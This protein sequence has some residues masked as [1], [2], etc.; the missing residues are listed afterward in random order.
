MTKKLLSLIWILIPFYFLCSCENDSTGESGNINTPHIIMTLPDNNSTNINCARKIEIYFQDLMLDKSVND[1]NISISGPAGKV[2]A[3]ITYD[4]HENKA[5]LAPTSR[6]N[7]STCYTV[8]IK[9]TILNKEQTSYT[10]DYTFSFTTENLI[11]EITPSNNSTGV[12]LKSDIM[13]KFK[14]DI[15]QSTLDSGIL[16]SDNLTGNLINRHI[17][18]DTGSKTATIYSDEMNKYNNSYSIIIKP[19]LKDLHNN[20]LTND[21]YN[22]FRT[23]KLIISTDPPDNADDFSKDQSIKIVF[24]NP[25]DQTS[26]S[27]SNIVLKDSNYDQT[28]NGSLNYDDTHK[29]LTFSPTSSLQSRKRYQL[30]IK[31]G[32]KDSDGNHP[33]ADTKITFSTTSFIKKITP[34]NNSGSIPVDSKIKVKFN[35][36]VD[37]TTLTSEN[38]IIKISENNSIINGDISYTPG[39]KTMTFTPD[40]KFEYYTKFIIEL[41]ETIKD[42]S[43]NNSGE[44]ILS[45][46]TTKK[47][48]YQAVKAHIF[49]NYEMKYVHESAEITYETDIQGD[50]YIG[51]SDD[52]D[53]ES[54]TEWVKAN[55][56]TFNNAGTVNTPVITKMFAKVV[57]NG[58]LAAPEYS[59]VYRVVSGQ[60][61]EDGKFD[62]V[63]KAPYPPVGNDPFSEG[64]QK[65]NELI[66]SWADGYAEFIKGYDR[67]TCSPDNGWDDPS[68]AYGPAT[69][70]NFDIICLGN[71]GEI[72]LTFS[73]GITDGP[74]FDFAVYENAF[75]SQ[76][77]AGVAGQM[78][79][80]LA[81][82]EVSSDGVNFLRFDSASLTPG[83]VGGYGSV[84]VQHIYGLAGTQPN[85]YGNDNAF[86]TPFD[87]S[88]LR[89]KKKVTEG[90]VDL[91]NITHVRVID[92]SG[93]AHIDGNYHPCYDSFGNI[94]HDAFKTWGSG[95][96]DLEAIAVMNSGFKQPTD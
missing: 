14:K 30:I 53:A 86:G 84:N 56:Y 58:S 12:E 62:K 27:L 71:H 50:I 74:G 73:T 19:A 42:N 9:K 41:K 87:L 37:E 3:I 26:L 93:T 69:G 4:N 92:I 64:V 75:V 95:G 48:S 7:Y 32:I 88:S 54:P 21:Y 18:Y 22:N 79:G 65:D 17:S 70:N 78:F 28:I 35:N 63:L 96:F 38:V 49:C 16:L 83:P 68:M 60:F 29:T 81:F 66:K 72:T 20:S 23:E 39:T 6:L 2:D 13:F 80:E 40:N 61:D 36:A 8:A 45:F 5:T 31:N 51:T 85:A 25:M 55:S 10:H 44:N 52:P 1:K 67:S 11:A 89:N 90:L 34:V 43:G 47:E 91:N 24:K 57:K 82:V 15:N 94:I 77:G 59:F 76:G 33:A 46:F